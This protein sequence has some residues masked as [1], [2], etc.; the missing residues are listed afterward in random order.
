VIA[1]RNPHVP[2]APEQWGELRRCWPDGARLT[3]AWRLARDPETCA[4]LLRGLPVDR[5]RLSPEGLAWSLEHRLVR[6]ER[7]IDLLLEEAS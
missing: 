4:D 1:S 2:I 7:P 6:L 3:A 5:D